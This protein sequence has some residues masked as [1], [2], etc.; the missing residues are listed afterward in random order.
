MYDTI[1]IG[2]GPS[3]MSAGIYL[4]NAN[5]NIIIFEKDAPG[6]KILKAKKI[7][8]YLG[9]EDIE[10]SEIAYKMYKQVM[11]LKIKI[12]IEKVID[13]KK[14]KEKI[15]VITNKGKYE[16]KTL[17]ITCGRIE[18]SLGL[19]KESNLI[20]NGISYCSKCDG[21]LYKDK[22][23]AVVGNNSESIEETIYLSNIAKKVYYIN[24]DKENISFNNDNIEVIND[25]QIISLNETLNKLSSITLSDNRIVDVSGLF[26]LNGYA[27]NIEFI[28]NLNIKNDNGYILVSKNMKTNVKGIY[29]AGDIIKKDLYQVITSASEG[30]IA[31]VNIVKELNK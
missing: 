29:A 23:I 22:I 19:E 3:G 31:A 27:P 13:V 30:A 15:I 4:K 11:D 7:N 24:Y 10:P 6:G 1:I 25:K 17:L 21:S 28:K 2:A 18:K 14:E 5:K 26:I 9:L 8:N 16:S 20:G 12:N